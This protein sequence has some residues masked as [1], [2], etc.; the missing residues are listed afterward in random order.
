MICTFYSHDFGFDKIVNIAEGIFPNAKINTGKEG[1]SDVL[2]LDIKG[3]LFSPSSHIRIQ[4]RQKENPSW[5]FEPGDNSAITNNLRGLYGFVTKLPCAND[6][7]KNLF[8]QKIATLNSEFSL[9]QKGNAKGIDGLIKKLASEFDA[10][11]FAQPRTSISQAKAQHFLN[12]DLKLILDQEGN[13]QVDTLQVSIKSAYFDASQSNLTQDQQ[14]RKAQNIELIKA[15]GIKVNTHLPCIESEADTTLRTP[16]EIAQRVCVLTITNLVAFNSITG[17]A[18]ASYLQRDNLWEFV[19][20]AEREFLANP[21]EEKKMY[22]T[23]K[24]EDIW[25]LLWAIN[26]VDELPF[27]NDLCQL[28][29]VPVGNY[30]TRDF[31][32]LNDFI[33][34]VTDT[35]PKAEIL[36]ANDLYYRLNWACVDARIKGEEIT[37]VQPGVVYERQYALNW[38]IRYMDQDW[39]DVSCDT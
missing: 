24:C 28:K 26:K 23:W 29:L 18:A 22:E 2:E 21:T 38:L 34:S 25:T 35:R 33:A 30:P 27:P 15:A 19:T 1:E 39:D 32:N 8:L 16:K 37:T 5:K 6:N 4:Y 17:E 9:S 7:L 20:P 13:S 14:D 31:D 36:N 11:V 12:S 10:V 3:G